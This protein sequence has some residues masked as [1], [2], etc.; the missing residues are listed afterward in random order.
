MA[1]ALRLCV[2]IVVDISLLLL[3]AVVP[4]QLKNTLPISN[5]VP[6]ILLRTGVGLGIR[7]EVKV[8]ACILVL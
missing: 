3:R 5:G 1:K 4:G 7:Q 6:R 8:K 2:P